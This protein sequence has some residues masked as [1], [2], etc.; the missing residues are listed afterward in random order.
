[1]RKTLEKF[2]S[3]GNFSHIEII[4]GKQENGVGGEILKRKIFFFSIA[5]EINP[6]Q[7]LS[8]LSLFIVPYFLQ[9]YFDMMIMVRKK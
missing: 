1:V 5:V 6:H 8:T 7:M 2:N 9:M 3:V 4:D